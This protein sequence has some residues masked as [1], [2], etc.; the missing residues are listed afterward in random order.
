MAALLFRRHK[1]LG[2][3]VV[4]SHDCDSFGARTPRTQTQAEL[5]TSG[6]REGE[7]FFVFESMVRSEGETA[8][9][10]PVGF[11]D[12]LVSGH[13]KLSTSVVSV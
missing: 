3:T 7:T 1:N 10:F 2:A 13:L 4:H 5:P 6:R 9:F 12:F 11:C 8:H